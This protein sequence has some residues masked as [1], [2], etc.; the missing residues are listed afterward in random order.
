M[1]RLVESSRPMPSYLAL[2]IEVRGSGA[3]LRADY[4]RRWRGWH[5][6]ECGRAFCLRHVDPHG[7][8]GPSGKPV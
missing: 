5:D 6:R 1:T 8:T 4:V 3:E 2:F 7:F